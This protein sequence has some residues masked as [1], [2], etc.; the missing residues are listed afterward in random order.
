MT[1]IGQVALMV[2]LGI[3]AVFA[4]IGMDTTLR[5]FVAWLDRRRVR[6]SDTEGR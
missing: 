5:E 1:G 2:W 6:P 4:L 3:V